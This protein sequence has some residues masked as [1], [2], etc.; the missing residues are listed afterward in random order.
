M[1]IKQMEQNTPGKMSKKKKK[2]KT[3]LKVKSIKRNKQDYLT[4]IK[5]KFPQE[6]VTMMKKILYIPNCVAQK[7]VRPRPIEMQEKLIIHSPCGR[8]H[9]EVNR[10][11][12]NKA[13]Q[14]LSQIRPRV[15]TFVVIPRITLEGNY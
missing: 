9:L 12:R 4:L 11:Q 8:F 7:Y 13:G 15:W 14:T 1:K 2:G 6:A 5:V 10:S 3:K